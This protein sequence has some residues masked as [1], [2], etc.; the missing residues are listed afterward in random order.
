[1]FLLRYVRSKKENV[2]VV[3]LCFYL[4][5]Y[6]NWSHLLLPTSELQ[7]RVL[8][9]LSTA[10]EQYQVWQKGLETGDGKIPSAKALKE[11][12][13]QQGEAVET[14]AK[15]NTGQTALRPLIQIESKYGQVTNYNLRFKDHRI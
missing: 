1:M 12:I 5:A 2:V 7:C 14:P 15:Y 8:A 13:K 6:N 10:Q 4:D 11:I 9:K 3:V